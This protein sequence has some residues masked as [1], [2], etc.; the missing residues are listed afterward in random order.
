MAGASN[1]GR[2]KDAPGPTAPGADLHWLA[3]RHVAIIEA[4]E[5]GDEERAAQ[6]MRVH[7]REAEE[8]VLATR[9]GGR[10]EQPA[11]V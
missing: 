5:S 9:T 4:L 6:Q 1:P 3:Q 2:D 11:A 7:A 10:V 8:Q